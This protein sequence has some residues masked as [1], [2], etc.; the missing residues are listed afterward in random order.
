MKTVEKLFNLIPKLETVQFIGLARLLG[1]KLV[2]LGEPDPETSKQVAE[3]RPFTEVLEDML[4]AFEKLNRK[5][6]REVFQL[7][8]QATKTRG[9][10]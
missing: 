10:D 5:R 9:D 2:V 3:P 8:K 4:R 6:Q 1:V 7:V